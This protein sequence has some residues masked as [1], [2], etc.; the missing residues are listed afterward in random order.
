MK[1]KWVETFFKEGQTDKPTR[2]W[3]GAEKC[4]SKPQWDI[5]SLLFGWL[6]SKWQQRRSIGEEAEK[7]RPLYTVEGNVSRC[8]TRENGGVSSKNKKELPC[9]PATVLLG[10]PP[11]KRESVSQSDTCILVFTAAVSLHNSQG[12]GTTS[13]SVDRWTNKGNVTR[14]RMHTHTHTACMH[15][16]AHTGMLFI[17]KKKDSCHLW[18]SGWTWGHYTEWNKPDTE[19]QIPHGLIHMWNLKNKTKKNSKIQNVDLVETE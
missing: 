19:R 15:A 17:H 11:K 12:V 1:K 10:V 2:A 7:K 16:C 4:T 6:L 8:N 13:V 5:T 14:T 9:D 3:K 18:Q